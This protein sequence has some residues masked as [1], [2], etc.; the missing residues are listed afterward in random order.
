MLWGQAVTP[1]GTE[2]D[3]PSKAQGEGLNFVLQR[4]GVSKS[5][6]LKNKTNKQKQPAP[7][8]TRTKQTVL[9]K[10]PEQGNVSILSDPGRL[11]AHGRN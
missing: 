10:I 9:G 4:K 7:F 8:H 5:K 1:D 3:H 2:K 6:C 11:I